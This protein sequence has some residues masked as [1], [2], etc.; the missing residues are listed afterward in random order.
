MSCQA[1]RLP[2]MEEWTEMH[3]RLKHITRK[4]GVKKAGQRVAGLGKKT[5]K[6]SFSSAKADQ[7]RAFN[8]ISAV[9]ESLFVSSKGGHASD[10]Q[11]V[12]REAS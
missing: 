11:D 3:G 2:M 12:L 9:R 1:L 7:E 4:I 10:F 8:K 5:S 6:E